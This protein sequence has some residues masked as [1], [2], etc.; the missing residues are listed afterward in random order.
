MTT[1]AVAPAPA[2]ETAVAAAPAATGGVT[3]QIGIFSVE[4]NADRAVETLRKAGLTANSRKET[5]QGKTWWSV[6][7]TGSGGR[8]ALLT[9]VKGLGFTDAY[10][11]R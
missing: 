8:D 10:A 6:T 2:Q 9:K 11:I 4:A 1:T 7:A 3:V 5:T